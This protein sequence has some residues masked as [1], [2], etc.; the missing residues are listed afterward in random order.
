M[1]IRIEKTFTVE[2]PIAAVWDFLTDP[3]RV[4]GCLPGA[5]ITEQVDDRTF[6]GQMT[7]KVGPVSSSYRGTITFDKL[8]V[9]TRTAELSGRGQDTRGK[10]GADMKM[11]SVLTERSQGTEA[12]VIS[13]VNVTGILAQ[14]GRGIIQDVSDQ[15]FQVFAERMR[16]ELVTSNPVE[17][18]AAS[19]PVAPAHPKQEQVL[20]VGALGAAAGKRALQRVLA[21]PGFWVGV[22][23]VLV[24]LYWILLQ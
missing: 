16:A 2:A 10:G 1:A 20:D 8:D 4:A 12:T 11:T 18:N 14:M 19:N 6:K 24:L 22:A 13:D 3:R 15:M 17:K 21:R 23:V 7:V 9:A 5:S